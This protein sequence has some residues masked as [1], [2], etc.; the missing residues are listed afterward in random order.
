MKPLKH[1][2]KAIS[3]GVII[4]L[5]PVENIPKWE[6]YYLIILFHIVIMITFLSSSFLYKIGT[7]VEPTQLQN[8]WK[9]WL[10]VKHVKAASNSAQNENPYDNKVTE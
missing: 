2:L 10:T 5:P 8:E 7:Y 3:L 9:K 4:L 1:M 6:V